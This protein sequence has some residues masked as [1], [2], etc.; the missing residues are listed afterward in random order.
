MLQQLVRGDAQRYRKGNEQ[1]N[2]RETG[3]RFP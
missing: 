3:S 2:V 1:G